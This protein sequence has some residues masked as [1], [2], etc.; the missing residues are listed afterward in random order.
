MSADS[1]AEAGK[2]PASAGVDGITSRPRIKQ[3]V[4]VKQAV[5]IT[6]ILL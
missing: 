6:I 4:S 5:T 3:G 1:E 2:S